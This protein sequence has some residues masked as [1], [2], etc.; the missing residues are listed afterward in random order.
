M[1]SI[2]ICIVCIVCIV[3][4]VCIILIRSTNHY[5][6]HNSNIMVT[7]KSYT[8]VREYKKQLIYNITQLFN[9]LQIK[10]VIGHGNL[11]EYERQE[12]IY[13]DDDI[14][15]RFD[16]NDIQKWKTYCSNPNNNT[17]IKYNLQFNYLQ[18][19]KLQDWTRVKLINFIGNIKPINMN[20]N[21]DI[22]SSN[23]KGFWKKNFIDKFWVDYNINYNNLRKIKYLEVDTYAPS[24]ED[25]IMILTKEYGPN[26]IKPNYTKYE[27]K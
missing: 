21:I 4:I 1:K 17:N 10:F 24:I 19:F 18:I 25:T 27:L 20:I 5:F 14:D 6:Q 9:E 7:T 8:Y 3:Y 22:V 12:P 16:I 2:Y 23:Y 26:Y 11:I 13:H 15:I